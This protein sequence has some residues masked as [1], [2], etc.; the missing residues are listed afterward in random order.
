M[1]VF[2]QI[3][4]ATVGVLYEWTHVV[5]DLSPPAFALLALGGASYLLGIP[6]FILGERKP[7][8]HVVWHLFVVMGAALHWFDVYFFVVGIEINH[9]IVNDVISK[10][11]A[12]IA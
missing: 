1:F 4:V 11:S 12:T 5:S 6:F 10:I 2:L 7:I 3:V 9:P 8:Y